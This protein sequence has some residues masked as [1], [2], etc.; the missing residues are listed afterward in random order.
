MDFI[1]E[2]HR[3]VHAIGMR[4]SD[5]L[6]ITQPEALVLYFLAPNGAAPLEDVHRA[7]LHKRSTLTNVLERLESRGLIER[8]VSPDDRRR[9]DLRLTPAGRRTAGKVTALFEEITA[10][11]PAS[12]S[13]IKT[14]A[15]VL[16]G[17]ADRRS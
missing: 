11:A 13:Q 4:V 8:A 10:S 15:R 12:S 3:A 5:E 6:D 1:A 7:F 17:I 16:A 2:L 9:F 14:A